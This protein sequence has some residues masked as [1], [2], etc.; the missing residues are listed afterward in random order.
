M[1]QWWCRE[2]KIDEMGSLMEADEDKMKSPST[3]VMSIKLVLWSGNYKGSLPL[4]P[5][6]IFATLLCNCA[7]IAT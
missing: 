6:A 3:V 7:H 2:D 4:N 1:R 5:E